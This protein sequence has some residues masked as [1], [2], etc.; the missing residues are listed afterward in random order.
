MAKGGVI[1]RAIVNE[2]FVDQLGYR[3]RWECTCRRDGWWTTSKLAADAGG[4]AHERRMT[5]KPTGPAAL[6]KLLTFN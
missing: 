2:T 5:P 3:Y 1:H 6:R 4:K